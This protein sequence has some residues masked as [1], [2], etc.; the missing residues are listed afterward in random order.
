SGQHRTGK[1]CELRR[2]FRGLHRFK[3]VCEL[4]IRGLGGPGRQTAWAHDVQAAEHIG[5]LHPDA[6]SAIPSHRVPDQPTAESIADGAVAS[7]DVRD[8]I[9]GD[10][11]LEISRGHRT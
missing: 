3:S 10:E 9:M 5:M 1:E 4:R 6:G 2:V 8:Y 11:F 7:V